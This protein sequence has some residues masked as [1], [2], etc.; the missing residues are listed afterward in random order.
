MKGKNTIKQHSQLREF[1]LKNAK[2]EIL[3]GLGGI[4]G[5]LGD[6]I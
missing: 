4:S 6:I 3:R 5:F 2:S 1:S